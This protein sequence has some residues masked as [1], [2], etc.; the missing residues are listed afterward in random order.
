MDTI[1][2]WFALQTAPKGEKK[3]ERSLSSK[4]YDCLLPTY[5]QRRRWSDRTVTIELPLFP[6]YVFCRFNPSAI[7]KA[8]T[9]P[10][11]SRIIRF[12][13]RPAEVSAHEI[14]A[15]QLL[16]ESSLLREP[17]AYI[18][19]GTRIKVET[20]PLAGVEGIICPDGGKSRL[21]ISITLLQRSVAVHLD[22]N[23]LVSVIEKAKENEGDLCYESGLSLQLVKRASR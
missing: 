18:P 9:T 5:W 4:G 10:G 11:V 7:G 15:L 20:G 17:W 22:D 1:N 8:I 21:I 23:M 19:A 12:G 16:A 13:G 2:P 6:R 14:E 3:V